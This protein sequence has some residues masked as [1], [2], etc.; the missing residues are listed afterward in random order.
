MILDFLM[1][2]GKIDFS[3]FLE[4]IIK[5]TKNTIIVGYFSSQKLNI[6]YHL[7]KV[8]FAIF[9]ESEKFYLNF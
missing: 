3:K 1:W 4:D 5:N 6:E 2:T 8:D 9:F 7:Q